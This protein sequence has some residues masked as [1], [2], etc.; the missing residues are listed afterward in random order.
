MLEYSGWRDVPK[1]WSI[2][3]P[4]PSFILE[5]QRPDLSTSTRLVS[6]FLVGVGCSVIT[7]LIRIPWRQA[8]PS[9]LPCA[10]P[11]FCIFIPEVAVQS[12]CPFSGW[13]GF[14]YIECWEF[15]VLIYSGCKFSISDVTYEYHFPVCGFLFLATRLWLAWQDLSS[16]QGSNP[17]PRQ[18]NWGVVT[19]ELTWNSH[20]FLMWWSL[21]FQFCP[22]L[23]MLLV[24]CLRTLC[25]TESSQR[26]LSRISS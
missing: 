20:K 13:D 11:H 25:L 10:V 26:F 1:W 16:N 15:F 12:F 7:G 22:L 23:T 21:T 17:G 2:H 18:W 24:L 9:T 5:L 19:I 6:G 3:L 14:L 4:P 8:K